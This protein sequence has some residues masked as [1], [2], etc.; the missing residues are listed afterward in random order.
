MNIPELEEIMRK[1]DAHVARFDAAAA[2]V[3]RRDRLFGRG[4][5]LATDSSRP[6]RIS[7]GDPLTPRE[8]Q[9]ATRIAEGMSNRE[10]ADALF[11]G[12][13]TVKS[14]LKKIFCK[15]GA[16]NRAHLVGLF[17]ESRVDGPDAH[18]RAA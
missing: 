2:I 6:S 7:Q 14:H 5:E 18:P 10:I 1:Y 17:M 11:I 3:A 16:N 13:E 4:T 8:I 9:V 12:I 15:L